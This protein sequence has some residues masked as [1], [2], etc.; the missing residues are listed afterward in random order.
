VGFEPTIAV[1]ERV[2]TLH[3]LDREA[4]MVGTREAIYAKLEMEIDSKNIRKFCV[5]FRYI[6]TYTGN[7]TSN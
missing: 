3:A 5:K 1:F 4:T 6:A 2:K 7:A